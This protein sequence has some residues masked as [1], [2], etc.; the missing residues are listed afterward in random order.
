MRW[1]GHVALMG[2]M[3]RE[4]SILVG[5]PEGRAQAEDIDV[6]EKIILEWI[7]GK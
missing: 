3:I 6:D 5:K 7:V 4:Y 2:H 1:T